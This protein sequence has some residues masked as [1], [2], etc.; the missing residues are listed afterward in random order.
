MFADVYAYRFDE[1]FTYHLKP[2]ALTIEPLMAGPISN[3]A[4]NEMGYLC[5][6][7]LY[8]HKIEYSHKLRNNFEL[9][10]HVHM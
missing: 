3:E 4:Y 10:S 9:I 1:Q 5:L 7:I 2:T 8:C 6:V